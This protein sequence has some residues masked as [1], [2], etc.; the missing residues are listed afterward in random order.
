[1]N[2]FLQMDAHFFKLFSAKTF[3]AQLSSDNLCNLQFLTNRQ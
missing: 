3:S 1:M 2:T